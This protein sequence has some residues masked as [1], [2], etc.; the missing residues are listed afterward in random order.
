MTGEVEHTEFTRKYVDLLV[1]V[2]RDEDEHNRIVADP[3]AYAI[4]AG[5]PVGPGE[6]V[7]LDRSDLEHLPT[8][9]DVMASGTR[10]PRRTSS[11]CRRHRSSTRPS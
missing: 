1:K 10:A 11:S 3:T 8:K 9:D 2:W 4:E 5:L 7:V 6:V